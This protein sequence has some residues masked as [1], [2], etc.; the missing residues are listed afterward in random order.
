M[1][2]KGNMFDA[3]WE[4]KFVKGKFPHNGK[5]SKRSTWEVF[6]NVQLEGFDPLAFS[7]ALGDYPGDVV[8]EGTNRQDIDN[9]ASLLQTTES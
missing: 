2:Y 9:S 6:G 1:D 3:V 8:P 5:I 4:I 7:K